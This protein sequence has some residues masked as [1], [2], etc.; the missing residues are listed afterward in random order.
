ML[1]RFTANTSSLTVVALFSSAEI[2]VHSL[3]RA[4]RSFTTVCED[5]PRSHAYSEQPET[6]HRTLASRDPRGQD[7]TSA[8]D[9]IP[10]GE[11]FLAT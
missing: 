7:S 5:D 1:K 10:V 9:L 3:S 2:V 8:F 4:H 11:R 6:I